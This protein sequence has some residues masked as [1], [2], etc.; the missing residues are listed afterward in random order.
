MVCVPLPP[1]HTNAAGIP[2]LREIVRDL[3]HQPGRGV[4]L[5]LE[6]CERERCFG[7]QVGADAQGQ[8]RRDAERQQGG[9]LHGEA[10]RQRAAFID[11]LANGV[12]QRLAGL[13][14]GFAEENGKHD[15]HGFRAGYRAWG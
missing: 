2:L 1:L 11:A 14:I 7:Q 3:A 12:Q 8:H 13:A 5:G 15:L 10:I 9:G 6:A 4:D